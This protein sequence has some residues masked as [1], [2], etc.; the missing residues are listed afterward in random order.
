MFNDL[1]PI[2]I[3]FMTA[4]GRI[5]HIEQ[6]KTVLILL[7]NGTID[8]QNSALTTKCNSNLISLNQLWESRISFHD[9][10]SSMTLIKD[11]KVIIEI[12]RSCN[13]FVLYLATSGK[14][15]RVSHIMDMHSVSKS[16]TRQAMARRGRSWLTY[17]VSK[18]KKIKIWYW[19]LRD[20]SNSRVI[21]VSALV[22]G[23]HLQQANYNLSE[24]CRLG[25]IGTQYRWEKQV[26]QLG[27]KPNSR[28]NTQPCS[29]NFSH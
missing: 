24:I 6:V 28:N 7:R 27:R 25:Q 16:P 22:N 12:R 18:N 15:M 8:L 13:L 3:D 4:A 9:N 5:I 14:V 2:C 17:L 1:R 10:P 11:R 23:I 29:T 21:G 26:R 20:A 19:Q